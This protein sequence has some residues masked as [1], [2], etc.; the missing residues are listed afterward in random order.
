M[1]C[2]PEKYDQK[3]YFVDKTKK[4]DGIEWAMD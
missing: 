4:M 3:M 1:H 2:M